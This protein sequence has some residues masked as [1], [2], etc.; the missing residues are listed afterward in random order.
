M[1]IF[2]TLALAVVLCLL[3]AYCLATVSS[4][5][6]KIIYTGDGTTTVFPYNFK[7]F[8]NTD[9]VVTLVVIASGAE[10]VQTITTDYTVSGVGVSA[11]GNVT[12]VTAPP[13]T[14]QLIIQRV[15]PLTQGTDLVDNTS[16]SLEVLEEGFD[17]D[18][19]IA[20][21]QQE[22]LDRSIIQ[23]VTETTTIVFPSPV[24]EKAIGR[25]SAVTKATR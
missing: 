18:I 1:K 15:L 14:D 25:P 4:T 13:S 17:R 12:M 11:G 16:F 9:L 6:N 8:A 5:D 21:Q 2:K 20:Q 7:I 3:P 19:M 24:A 22:Q 23:S 10:T